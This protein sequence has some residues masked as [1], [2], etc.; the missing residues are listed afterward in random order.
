MTVFA[1]VGEVHGAMHAMVEQVEECAR[2]AR[3]TVERVLQVG[4]FEPHRSPA[5]VAVM[6]GPSRYREC[7]DF[8]DFVSGRASFPWPVLFIGGNHEPWPW[9]DS[10]GDHEALAPGCRFLGRSGVVDWRGRRIGG[11]SGIYREE[12]YRDPRP[13]PNPKL[14][15]R[16]WIDFRESDV[17]ALLDEAPVDILLLHDWPAG[18]LA[19]V[20]AEAVNAKLRASRRN[21]GNPVARELVERL[22]PGF[23]FCGHVHHRYERRLRLPSGACC[24]VIALDRIRPEL[25]R[26][27]RHARRGPLE[28]PS[29]VLVELTT[30][31]GIP[32]MQRVR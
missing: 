9:L 8:R 2:R 29:V 10:L 22:E 27:R 16:T 12:S 30:V 21:P 3:V 15:N 25:S 14:S 11:L 20:D 13:A 18:V 6:H 32:T 24:D 5:D 19:E 17:L 4:D 31:A 7:G 23:V 26:S 1:V 28:N